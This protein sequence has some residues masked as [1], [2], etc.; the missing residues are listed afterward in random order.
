[1]SL[2]RQLLVLQV[3]IVGLLVA[4]GAVFISVDVARDTRANATEKV[5]SVASTVADAPTVRMAAGSADPTATLQPLAERIRQDTGVDFITI[6]DP[7]G[8]RWTHPNPDMIGGQFLGH[9]E[10]ALAGNVFTET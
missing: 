10:Q 7:R 3:I 8:R 1:M 5:V 6:M 2:A 4:G 9:T